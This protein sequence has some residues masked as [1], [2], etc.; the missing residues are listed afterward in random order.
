VTTWGLIGASDIAATKMIPAIRA[1]GGTVRAVMS[2]SAEHAKA[3]ATLHQIE[4][5]TTYLD[6]VLGDDIQ[7]VYISSTN[8]KHFVQ[9]E[10]ALMAGKHVMCEKPMA[11]SVNE[12]AAMVELAEK[13]GLT[14]AI[15]HHLPGNALHR[16]IREMV[17]SGVIGGILAAQVSHA[18]LLHE[19]LRGWRLSA[20]D[21]GAGVI[22]DLTCH[23]A[24][25]LNRLLGT[26]TSVTAKA[27][28]QADWNPEGGADTAMTL[29]EYMPESGI[30]VLA[31]TF[32]SFAMGY[33]KTHLTLQGTKGSLYASDAMTQ[34][35]SGTITVTNEAGNEVTVIDTAEDPY[36]VSVEG[37]T[38]ALVT[39]G[40]PT[41]SG[42]EGLLALQVALAAQESVLSGRTIHLG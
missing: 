34:D 12:A 5:H 11:L 29:I 24:S 13:R 21:A 4:F 1:T 18:G 23:D 39:G 35:S 38:Q 30:P 41:V 9:T 15:N 40:P 36:V 2:G 6:Q 33:G 10:R 26:P 32:D 42:T 19:R 31:Q 16:R 27:V 20:P 14:L 8:E 3:F 37:F 22:L 7:A 28:S 17:A 25:V